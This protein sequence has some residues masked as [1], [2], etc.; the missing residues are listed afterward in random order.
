MLTVEIREP[1]ETAY[2]VFA[3]ISLYDDGRVEMWDPTGFAKQIMEDPIPWRFEDGKVRRLYF[4]DNPGIWL[5]HL[6]FMLRSGPSVP[7][8]VRDD[9]ADELTREDV[10]KRLGVTVGTWSGYV[11]RNQAPKPTRKIGQTPVWSTKVIDEW[12]ASRRGQGRKRL[13][14]PVLADEVA[15]LQKEYRSMV[16]GMK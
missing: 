2:K 11:S 12:Q 13:P 7:V 6:G 10:A 14:Q 15:D 8:I 9:E 16:E 5:R 3:S 1:G 4:Q